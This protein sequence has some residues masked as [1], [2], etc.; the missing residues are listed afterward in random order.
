MMPGSVAAPAIGVNNSNGGAVHGGAAF[1]ASMT[2]PQT[3][4][5]S[6]MSPNPF[7]SATYAYVTLIVIHVD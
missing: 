1:G 4:E 3:A 6:L 7:L 5:T 2:F